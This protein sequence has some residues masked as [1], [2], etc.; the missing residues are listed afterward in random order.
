MLDFDFEDLNS[1]HL[2]LLSIIALGF[3]GGLPRLRYRL[4]V[5]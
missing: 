3:L 1:I 2:Q 5:S 4:S